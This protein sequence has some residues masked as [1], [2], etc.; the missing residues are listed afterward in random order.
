[1]SNIPMQRL[2]KSVEELESENPFDDLHYDGELPDPL[3][4]LQLPDPVNVCCS[5]TASFLNG[6]TKILFFMVVWILRRGP[7]KTQ[8]QKDSCCDSGGFVADSDCSSS[9]FPLRCGYR[10]SA[11]H[12]TEGRQA[13]SLQP[14]E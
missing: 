14:Y 11:H 5:S 8:T 10:K 13:K 3:D 1:M 6:L 2:D 7:E 12:C 4:D 9:I